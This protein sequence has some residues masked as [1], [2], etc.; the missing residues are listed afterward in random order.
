MKW[1]LQLLWLPSP[2]N[3]LWPMAQERLTQAESLH[4]HTALRRQRLE[5]GKGEEG[6]VCRA[7]YQRGSLVENGSR[8][9]NRR[10]LESVAEYYVGWIC[11]TRMKLQEATQRTTTSRT[12]TV[13]GNTFQPARGEKSHWNLGDYSLETAKRLGLSTKANLVLEQ[14]RMQP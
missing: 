14:R 3:P 5:F 9:L 7:E 13:L 1:I 2:G 10:P 11:T 8:N 4:L 6:G 12:Y